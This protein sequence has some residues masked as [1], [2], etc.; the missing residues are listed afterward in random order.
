MII[1]AFGL[2]HFLV[3]LSR[4]KKD[5]RIFIVYLFLI[6]FFIFNFTAYLHQYFYH[7]P[8][9][10]W[11]YWAYG[12]QEAMQGINQL[13][14]NYDQ[15]LINNTYEPSILWFLFWNKYSPQSFQRNYHGG[16][17]QENILP[18]F[19]GFKLDKFYFGKVNDEW[20]KKGGVDKVLSE[21]KKTLFLITQMNEVGGDWDWR[22]TSPTGVKVLK[23]ITNPYG[24]IIFYLV[25]HE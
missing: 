24:Q 11:R 12:Y 4:F 6:V 25:T 21:N 13:E 3:W 23:T 14:K 8:K 22:Q 18:G 5:W 10:S 9:E 20:V 17:Y 15:V 1:S 7:Y 19:D 2:A 16:Q